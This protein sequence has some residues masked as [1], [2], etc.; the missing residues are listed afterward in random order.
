MTDL[1]WEIAKVLGLP[2]IAYIVGVWLID[3]FS[4]QNLI[5]DFLR[6]VKAQLRPDSIPLNLRFRGYTT[7]AVEQYWQPL[8]ANKRKEE[9]RFLWLDLLFP[10]LYGSALII[11]IDMA[12]AHLEKTSNVLWLILPKGLVAVTCL[13]DWTENI[14]LLGQIYRSTNSENEWIPSRLQSKW[15]QVASWATQIKLFAFIA[16]VLL[17]I[18]LIGQWQI[19]LMEE[20]NSVRLIT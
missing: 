12:W 17:L 6:W 8:G 18:S 2:L 19:V 16:S 4:G 13:A 11:S 9:K 7:H 1:W 10:L 20:L 3:K 5:P 14:V 15:I